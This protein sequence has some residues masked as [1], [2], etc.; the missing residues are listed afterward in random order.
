MHS[1]DVV[2]GSGNGSGEIASAEQSLV[3]QVCH[4]ALCP[5]RVE[6]YPWDGHLVA[7]MIHEVGATT[8]ESILDSPQ[9]APTELA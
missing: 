6:Q 4:Y 8:T 7:W 9:S 5:L 3:K 1:T 2:E